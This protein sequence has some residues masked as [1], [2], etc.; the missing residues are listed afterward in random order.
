MKH[1]IREIPAEYAEFSYYF[2]YDGLTSASGEYC[3]NLFIIVNEGYGRIWGFNIDEYKNIQKEAEFI[4][5]SFNNIGGWY[6]YRSYKE[7]MESYGITYNPR[8]CH[9]L[10]EWQKTPMNATPTV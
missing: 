4:I 2:D 9:L 1:I 5:D 7:A 6:G 8:K 3:N 10:K